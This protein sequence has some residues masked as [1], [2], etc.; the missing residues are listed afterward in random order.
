MAYTI[1]LQPGEQLIREII[2]VVS[3]KVEPFYLGVTNQALYL[4]AKKL[5][6]VSDP[7]YYRRVQLAEVTEVSIRRMRPYVLWFIAGLMLVAGLAVGILMMWPF[8]T[9]GVSGTFTV[10]GWPV[11]LCVGGLLIP[12][13]AHGRRGLIIRW[14]KG[15]FR[16]KPPLVIDRDSKQRIAETLRD[17]AAACNEAKLNVTVDDNSPSARR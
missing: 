7:Y 2:L 14:A 1:D 17:I 4:P 16:W 8:F 5:I 10:S 12:F 3:P 15:K 6:A 13:A 9:P 11:A